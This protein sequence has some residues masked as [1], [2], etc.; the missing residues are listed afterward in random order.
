[1]NAADRASPQA[2]LSECNER[3]KRMPFMVKYRARA[4]SG[5]IVIRDFF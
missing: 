3:A 4:A 5:G 1:M 2:H